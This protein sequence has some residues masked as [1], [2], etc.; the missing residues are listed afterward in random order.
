[1]KFTKL[2]RAIYKYLSGRGLSNNQLFSTCFL[3]NF[4]YLII[5]ENKLGN[6]DGL[7]LP[8]SILFM[9]ILFVILVILLFPLKKNTKFGGII[10]SAI[11]APMSALFIWYLPVKRYLIL[12]DRSLISSEY[13]NYSIIYIVF[14]SSIVVFMHFIVEFSRN[15][16]AGK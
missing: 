10:S 1:M 7:L 14:I 12:K 5:F 9:P 16:K 2:N 11:I 15:Y 13:F 8:L 3:F 4:F 6:E